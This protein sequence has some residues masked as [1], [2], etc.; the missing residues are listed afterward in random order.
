[1]EKI[2]EIQVLEML[3][4]RRDMGLRVLAADDGSK[5]EF[6]VPGSLQLMKD[7]LGPMF[8]FQ[9]YEKNMGK[10]VTVVNG[11]EKLMQGEDQDS[12]VGCLDDNEHSF[13]SALDLLK[14]IDEG[15]LGAIGTIN[16]PPEIL[17]IIDRNAMPAVGAIESQLMN[18]KGNLCI[19]AS[20]YWINHVGIVRTAMRLYPMYQKLFRKMFPNEIIKIPGWGTP[21][22]FQE[23]MS[24]VGKNWDPWSYSPEEYRRM[25]V[26][27]LPCNEV[28]ALTPLGRSMD[29]ALNQLRA[30]ILNGYV[31]DELLGRNRDKIINLHPKTVQ[32]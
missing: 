13:L 11:L 10:T 32:V 12:L 16:Y 6:G 8:D 30:L 28:P 14:R 2:E 1:M 15:Y 18:L 20:G 17:N 7:T 26:C 22:L 29:K 3:L 31:L 25:A 24:Y 21:T 27:Y 5:T 19:Y 23:F 9:L 4:A